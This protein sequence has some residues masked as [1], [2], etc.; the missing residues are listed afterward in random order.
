MVIGK[1]DLFTFIA[2][3]L[4]NTSIVFG[5]GDAAGELNIAGAQVEDAVTPQVQ[6]AGPARLDS[7]QTP[8]A[9]TLAET[10]S[11]TPPGKPLRTLGEYL[12]SSAVSGAPP[13]AVSPAGR[14][15]GG[16]RSG[17]GGSRT[18]RRTPVGPKTPFRTPRESRPARG[19][20]PASA[21]G[22]GGCSDN[23]PNG[24]ATAGAGVHLDQR[25]SPNVQTPIG[26][27]SGG[28]SMSPFLGTPTQGLDSCAPQAGPGPLRWRRRRRSRWW[29][30]RCRSAV[31]VDVSRDSRMRQRRARG[32][33]WKLASTFRPLLGL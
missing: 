30:P 3:Q 20:L 13:C 28:P 9:E 6:G 1:Q 31:E 22:D 32:Q 23:T 15:F 17:A 29:S 27:P 26:H 12:P 8:S 2:L 25:A 21:R 7:S 19:A 33:L 24:A 14:Y 11:G 18:S 4:K 5:T 16:V 10:P